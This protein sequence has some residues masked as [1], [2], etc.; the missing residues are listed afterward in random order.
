[1]GFNITVL[2]CLLKDKDILLDQLQLIE[3][4]KDDPEYESPRSYG[5]LGDYYLIWENWRQVTPYDEGQIAAFSK[6]CPILGC[7][8]SE[9]TMW[10]LAARF[11]NGG[12]LWSV[13]HTG[14]NATDD[15]QV[16]GSPPAQWAAIVDAI[17]GEASE[18]TEQTVDYFFDGPARLFKS[19]TGFQYDEVQDFGFCE[20]ESLPAKSKQKPIWKF[21]A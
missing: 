4:D 3:T 5:R 7:F 9:A 11:E 14:E 17:S 16:V 1:M 21:W 12:V 13:S 20:L 15:L 8:I 2:A 19:V 18:D 6:S 10:S